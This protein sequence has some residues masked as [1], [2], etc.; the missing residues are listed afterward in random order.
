MSTFSETSSGYMLCKGVAERGKYTNTHF[1][2]SWIWLT[3]P[4][5]T[6]YS[7][8]SEF[9][10]FFW[11]FFCHISLIF[12]DSCTDTC[13]PSDY[14]LTRSTSC[15]KVFCARIFTWR[16][17]RGKLPKAV[18][19][20]KFNVAS[21]IIVGIG[22]HRVWVHTCTISYSIE[23]LLNTADVDGGL[24]TATGTSKCPPLHT[25]T[26]SPNY[27]RTL[28]FG[29][30]KW[31]NLII[32]PLVFQL[33]PVTPLMLW[34]HW[35]PEKLKRTSRILQRPPESCRTVTWSADKS[36]KLALWFTPVKF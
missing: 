25:L 20:L 22:A 29:F 30:R 2:F 21:D 18:S 9:Q 31:K 19:F 33:H 23:S 8:F 5:P 16:N 11:S 24:C 28:I 27:V 1:F 32:R 12:L 14:Q 10:C 34:K 13:Y 35:K 36:V 17:I 6:K 3:P 7:M 26:H 4:P 15:S